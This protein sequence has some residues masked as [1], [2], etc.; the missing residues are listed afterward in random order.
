MIGVRSTDEDERALLRARGVEVVDMRAIDEWGVAAPMRE[1]LRRVKARNGLIPVSLEAD[2]LDPDV[3]P[4][5]GT[6]VPGSATYSEAH[7][8]MELLHDSGRV[9]AAELADMNPF[10]EQ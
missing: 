1:F 9:A 10:L 8:N 5:A 4:G 3:A 2:F 7:L 6:A